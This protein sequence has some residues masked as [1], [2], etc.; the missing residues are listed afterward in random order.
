M[1]R[2]GL[3]GLLIFYLPNAIHFPL[4]SGVPGLNVSNILF[5][6]ALFAVMSA[7]SDEPVMR[8]ERPRLLTALLVWFAALTLGFAVAQLRDPMNIGTDF[9]YL[10]NAIFY[11]LFYI[12]FL[13]SRLNATQTRSL[14]IFAMVVAAIAGIEAVREGLSFGFGNYSPTHRASGPFGPD[15]RNSNRA[16]VFYAM[17]LPVFVALAIYLRGVRF[18]R[19]AAITA[20]MVLV[21]AILATYSRQAY[22]ISIITVGI[23]LLRRNLTIG[24]MLA[25]VLVAAI[26]LLPEGV[27]ERVEHTEQSEGGG[28]E[29]LDASTTSRFDIWAG[30]ANMWKAHPGGIGLNRFKSHI[31]DYSH[32]AGFDA[33]NYYVLTISELGPHGLFA[34][35]FLVV[36][37]FRLTLLVKNKALSSKNTEFVALAYGFTAMVGA[38]VL[39][40]LY[41]SPFIEGS[42]MANFWI[43]CGLLERYARTI[44]SP[45]TENAAVPGRYVRKHEIG[46]KFPLARRANPQIYSKVVFD[47]NSIDQ[48]TTKSR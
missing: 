7:G 17:F 1:I 40:N 44:S 46:E 16:G 13:K 24:V 25:V 9:A 22:V 20:S 19:I 47:K 39:G 27:T 38:M 5:L 15:Y 37:L 3:L 11:P 36:S 48:R 4:E 6:L 26:P 14:I 33:H 31:G 34:L 21:V 28:V 12:L 43:V 10:K 30:A 29:S 18:W 23:L 45:L 41:G 8:A 2:I 35:I 42:V 32:Y